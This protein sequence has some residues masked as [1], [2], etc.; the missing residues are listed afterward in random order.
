MCLP[1]FLISIESEI[2]VHKILVCL[3]WF[4]LLFRAVHDFL[5]AA[6]VQQRARQSR[7]LLRQLFASQCRCVPGPLRLHPADSPS[8]LCVASV[9][10][11]GC[12][13]SASSAALSNASPVVSLSS[14]GA[15]R[16][17]PVHTETE[18]LPESVDKE[19]RGVD[20]RLAK[21]ARSAAGPTAL[22]SGAC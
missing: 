6:R 15:S 12:A 4:S 10:R 22:R 21:L 9:P 2:T 8:A 1:L 17:P 11:A 20:E 7:A 19:N 5:C 16:V 3:Y 14:T 18:L 13:A